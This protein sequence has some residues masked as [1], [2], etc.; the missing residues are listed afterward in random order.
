[1][2][3]NKEALRLP[4]PLLVRFFREGKINDIRKVVLDA[5]R[6]VTVHMKNLKAPLHFIHLVDVGWVPT[7]TCE[8]K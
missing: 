3:N 6:N 1:M 4:D 2:E 7:G 8:N 5:D